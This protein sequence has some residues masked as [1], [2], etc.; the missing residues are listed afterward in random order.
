MLFSFGWERL[1]GERRRVKAVFGCSL[2]LH[3][4]HEE[5]H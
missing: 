1:G 4:A 3:K 5:T 2:E